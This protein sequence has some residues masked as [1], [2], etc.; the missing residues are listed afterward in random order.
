MATETRE[1]T[2]QA[3]A[4]ESRAAELLG[5]RVGPRSWRH[6]PGQLTDRAGSELSAEILILICREQSLEWQGSGAN[7]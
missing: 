5:T 6:C 2:H 1:A 4:R 7:G 3:G